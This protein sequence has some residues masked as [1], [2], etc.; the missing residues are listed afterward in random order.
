MNI[1][2]LVRLNFC[3]KRCTRTLSIFNFGKSTGDFHMIGMFRQQCRIVV[4]K[5][6]CSFMQNS[7]KHFYIYCHLPLACF[8][9]TPFGTC[10]K[11][12][13]KLYVL[14]S[15]LYL[16]PLAI[17]IT[18][19]ILQYFSLQLSFGTVIRLLVLFHVHIFCVAFFVSNYF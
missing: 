9:I 12:C 10:S 1:E 3:F 17:H 7:S 6:C 5:C 11:Q 13:L 16:C 14:C 15:G 19:P 8:C 2:F 18:V 4:L